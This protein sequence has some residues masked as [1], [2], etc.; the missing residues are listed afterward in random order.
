MPRRTKCRN[1]F[2]DLNAAPEK[3]AL[4][5][6]RVTRRIQPFIFKKTCSIGEHKLLLPGQKVIRVHIHEDEN[7]T[8]MMK[9]T[10]CKEGSWQELTGA[11]FITDGLE[12]NGPALNKSGKMWCC[13]QSEKE[14]EILRYNVNSNNYLIVCLAHLW[15]RHQ[16]FLANYRGSIFVVILNDSCMLNTRYFQYV[17]NMSGKISCLFKRSTSSKFIPI[18]FYFIILFLFFFSTWSGR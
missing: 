3:K 12:P 1:L 14:A 8:F 13:R 17:W 9:V 7:R 2:G 5:Q 16:Y 10:F 15:G 4:R 11:G 18:I 6:T